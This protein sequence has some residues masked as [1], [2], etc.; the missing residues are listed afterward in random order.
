MSRII[1][2]LKQAVRYARGDKS[3]AKS[4]TVSVPNIAFLSYETLMEMARAGQG[5]WVKNEDM[6][7]WANVA[8][9]VY[10]TEDGIIGIRTGFAPPVKVKAWFY[11]RLG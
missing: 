5:E 2:S 7:P 4:Y 8:N 3:A 6:Q 1:K 9:R 10:R 11:P